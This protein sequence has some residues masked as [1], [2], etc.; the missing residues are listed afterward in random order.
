MGVWGILRFLSNEASNSSSS[1][2]S[3]I[4][5]S[6]CTESA[7]GV[8]FEFRKWPLVRLMC[9]D[10]G[11]LPAGVTGVLGILN[12]FR[13]GVIATRSGLIPSRWYKIRGSSPTVDSSYS[14]MTSRRYSR[15]F[16]PS[17]T[18]LWNPERNAGRT[19]GLPMYIN[20]PLYS[21][22][23][24]IL[25]K[26]LQNNREKKIDLYYLARTVIRSRSIWIRNEGWWIVIRTMLPLFAMS[27]TFSTTLKALVES[28]PEVG[29]SRKRSDGLWIMSIPMDTLLL[30]P[31]DTPLLP[32]FPIYVC[33]VLC[34][35]G[36]QSFKD[37]YRRN[38]HLTNNL[39]FYTYSQTEL[40]DE[41][42]DSPPFLSSGDR[43]RKPHFRSE[44]ERL[45]NG[46]HR[47]ELIILHNVRWNHLHITCCHL[48]RRKKVQVLSIHHNHI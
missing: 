34:I 24:L 27:L 22:N 45:V 7:L 43:W 37:K 11:L 30:S 47:K 35:F 4:L 1:S 13:T 36:K 39:N 9:L 25:L 46:Q 40:I 10:Q 32:S 29:S 19:V 44:H 15:L 20:L 23:K 26:P 31:P 8:M 48:K 18:G 33:V 17:G 41:L 3:P 5:D 12:G 42:N 28:R 16:S 2:S 14:L 38:V 21:F 6:N